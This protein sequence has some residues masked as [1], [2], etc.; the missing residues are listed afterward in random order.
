MPTA[1]PPSTDFTGASVTEGQFKT[2]LGA[3]RTFLSDLLGAD[4]VPATARAALAAAGTG[5]SNTF[6]KAQGVAPVGLT[7]AANIATDAALSNIFNVTLAGN[8]TLDNPTNLVA[9]FSYVWNINQDATG[10]RTLA[11]GTLF[12]FVGVNTLS[13]GANAKDTLACLYDGTILRCTLN[14]GYA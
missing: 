6:T 5:V 2:A 3:L 7:D 1:L 14:K 4:G 12:K 10:A 9:G 8:R 11:Y 13:T